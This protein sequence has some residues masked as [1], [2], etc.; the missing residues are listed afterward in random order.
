MNQ[1]KGFAVFFSGG[2]ILLGGSFA[3]YVAYQERR[4]KQLESEAQG[5]VNTE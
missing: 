4:K 1:K 5:Q 2:L 3:A